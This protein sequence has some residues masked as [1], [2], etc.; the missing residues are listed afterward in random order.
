M[1]IVRLL[2]IALGVVLLLQGP[3]VQAQTVKA[4]KLHRNVIAVDDSEQ[5]YALYLPSNYDSKKKWPVLIGFSPGANGESV[6]KH[7]REGAERFGWIVAGSNV[8]R[9]GPNSVCEGAA[10]AM[11]ADLQ[12]RFAVDENRVYAT[13][14]SGG[15]GFA[16]W[17]AQSGI[18]DIKGVFVHARGLFSQ[19]PK[20]RS[21]TFYFLFTGEADFNFGESVRFVEKAKQAGAQA[22]L[23]VQPGSHGWSSAAE[24]TAAIRFAH[25]LYRASQP[26]DLDRKAAEVWSQE[27]EYLTQ[28]ML[29]PY[30]LPAFER[31]L[32]LRDALD[33]R[34]LRAEK[35]LRK[36]KA[37]WKGWQKREQWERP[38]WDLLAKEG[39][40]DTGSGGRWPSS[41]SL[42]ATEKVLHGLVKDQAGTT[43]A[44]IAL[45]TIRTS[46]MSLMRV[47]RANPDAPEA[48]AYQGFIDRSGS[49][50]GDPIEQAQSWMKKRQLD[51]AVACLYLAWYLPGTSLN[52]VSLNKRK[53]KP[54][55]RAAG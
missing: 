37:N 48:P 38:A 6:V 23:S 31:M 54:L 44:H 11:W 12:K 21:N 15:G 35:V 4:G 13:G 24:C 51:R 3:L 25:L 53:W 5:S 8:S 27:V 7:Y 33:G 50:D 9:N 40:F 1:G 17:L 26:G 10:R 42:L 14:M 2:S 47:L 34:G 55:R 49:F 43:A 18:V 16:T 46:P 39:L 29:S 45:L 19:I 22:Y 20:E 32:W 30:F 36:T 41:D 52:K 28:R